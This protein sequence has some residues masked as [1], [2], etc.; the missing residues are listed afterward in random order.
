MKRAFDLAILGAGTVSPNP[1]VGAVI[2]HNNRIIGEGW[3]EKDGASHAEVNAV[4]NVHANDKKYLPESTIYVSLEPCC[5]FGRTPPCTDLIIK[6]KIPKVVISVIDKTDG[7]DGNG[8]KKLREAGIEITTGILENQ[9][10]E[11]S[12][13]RNHYVSQKRP[14]VILKYAQSKDGFFSKK[15]EQVWLSNQFSKRLVHK[16]RSEIDA[17]LVGTNTAKVDNPQLTNRLYFGKS[18]LRIVLDRDCSL[19]RESK[20][21]DDSTPTWII[22]N[23]KNHPKAKKQTTYH[24]LSFDNH[25]F[26]NILQLLANQGCNTLMVEGGA[27]L[28]KT[29]LKSDL[30]DE[31]RILESNKHLRNGVL[32]PELKFAKNENLSMSEFQVMDNKLKFIKKIP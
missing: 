25:L 21:L 3:Y 13:Y 5:I 15:N 17:I 30:W 31:I 29:I 32:A 23:Q 26:K 16:W 7:V 11:I 27:K 22:T 18:P 10:K 6:E 24:F 8:L 9:G 2:V 12:A 20:L 4:N 19:S 14:Y 1:M 28:L